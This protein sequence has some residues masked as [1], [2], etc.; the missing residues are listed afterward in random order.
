MRLH[1]GAMSFC[2]EERPRRTGQSSSAEVWGR[3]ASKQEVAGGGPH[4]PAAVGVGCEIPSTRCGSTPKTE[5]TCVQE[6]DD[7]GLEINHWAA[8]EFS[9][10]TGARRCSTINLNCRRP[11]PLRARTFSECSFDSGQVGLG[12]MMGFPPLAHGSAKASTGFAKVLLEV[13]QFLARRFHFRFSGQTI[14]GLALFPIGGG[15]VQPLLCGM[16]HPLNR[17]GDRGGCAFELRGELLLPLSDFCQEDRFLRH[18]PEL[19]DQS[20]LAQQPD[21]PLG[22]IEL[23]RFHTVAVIVLKGVVKVVVTLAEREPR[24]DGAVARRA[25]AGVGAATPGVAP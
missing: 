25:T 15:Q 12:Q 17:F 4:F 5:Q 10:P 2:C 9:L 8:M 24:Q 21:A 3:F 7:S 23:P 11:A 20:D 1:C 19:A 22:R 16:K 14:R 18:E 6:N 13:V